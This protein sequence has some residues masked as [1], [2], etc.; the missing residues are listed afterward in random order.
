M[1]IIISKS[2]KNAQK[3]ERSRIEQENY[4]QQY[5]YDNPEAIP[6]YDIKED[7][8]LLILAR[9]FSTHSGSID[10]IG[11]D[12][13]GEIY[14]IETKL[15]K[16]PDKRTVVAQSLDYGAALWKHSNDFDT[17]TATLNQSV[18]KVFGMTLSEKIEAFFGLTPEEIT[19]LL[20]SVKKNLSNGVMHFV[21]LMDVLDD[22]LKD[23]VLYVNQNSQFD[24]YAVE[25]DY[26]KHENY[27]IIIPKIY[28]AE[29]K[30]DIAVSSAT[31]GARKMWTLESFWE[32][33]K[34][35][36]STEEFKCIKKLYKFA[37]ET[38]DNITLGTGSSSGSFNPKYNKISVRSFFS[39]FSDGKIGLN[40]GY[41]DDEKQMKEFYNSL[42]KYLNTTV[43]D[44]MDQAR[45]AHLWPKLPTNEL[46]KNCDK[47]IEAIK[48]FISK[49]TT[50]P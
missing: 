21:I 42:N 28:G 44:N 48:D 47:F 20:D 22:R 5:I 49:E 25:L 36:L 32:D 50:K 4:L 41:L 12:K 18:Q 10:A 7:I 45:L 46:I 34:N 30:K 40:V 24:I 29:V 1:A 13:D 16:N 14:I 33:A 43:L 3:V 26:Y 17:F 27:E 2:G 35:R 15:Y 37:E 38:A 11:I 19:V 39:V 9:E 31:A 6:I 8:Q 23:L